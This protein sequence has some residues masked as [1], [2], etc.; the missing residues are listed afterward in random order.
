MVK[1]TI[2]TCIRKGTNTSFYSLHQ[3]NSYLP[4]LPNGLTCL[5][6][7]WGTKSHSVSHVQKGAVTMSISLSSHIFTGRARLLIDSAAKN[8]ELVMDVR[9]SIVPA[10]G[11]GVKG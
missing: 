9:V 11:S 8:N 6:N 2:N 5:G 3:L 10:T 7:F 1:L 4:R